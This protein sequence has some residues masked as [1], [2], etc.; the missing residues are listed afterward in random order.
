M[1]F[2]AAAM[3]RANIPE[4]DRVD[5][6][7]YVD[8]FQNFSTE[9]FATIMSE[10]RKYHLNLIVA[11]QF[12][13]Q[14]TDEIR[15]S[16]FGN[17][18]TI[19][20]FRVGQNDVE[21]LSKYFQPQFSGEDLLRLPNANTISRT[22]INGVPTLPF[23]MATLPPL[24][25]PNAKLAE[26]LKDLSDAKY[27]R[28]KDEV[29]KEVNERL[30]TKDDVRPSYGGLSPFEN[31]LKWPSGPTPYPGVPG[32]TGP[33]PS[34]VPPRS[35]STG[36]SFLDD[37]L[38]KRRSMPAPAPTT[39]PS[40]IPISK[41]AAASNAADEILAP[42]QPPTVSALL[43]TPAPAPN[44][45]PLADIDDLKEQLR[46]DLVT[47]KPAKETKLEPAFQAQAKPVTKEDEVPEPKETHQ[48]QN[49]EIIIDSE[50]NLVQKSGYNSGQN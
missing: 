17:M 8:E 19:I 10:A 28:P 7:L 3:S 5:F 22:L 49:G 43:P 13:T 33:I 23:S 26:A 40:Q 45:S 46:S 50:G 14:L 32:T 2:Q 38:N 24:G 35:S 21:I 34:S 48:P 37:W 15:D 27:G 1:K 18:G 20:S 4:S 41:P 36:S 42:V 31:A 29:E 9:S 30:T 39:I 47:K 6:T 44:A 12:T 11:N 16:V 25:K